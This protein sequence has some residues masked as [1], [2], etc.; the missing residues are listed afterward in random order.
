MTGGTRLPDSL[1]ALPPLRQVIAAHALSA[2]RGLGQNF[3]LDMNLTARIARAAGPLDAGTVIEIGPGPGGLTRALLQA[4]AVRLVAVEKDP[5]CIAAL[6]DLAAAAGGRLT[7]LAADA[8]AVDIAA[9][10]PPPRRI[11]AN[12]PFNIATPL[13]LSWVRRPDLLAHMVLMFQKEVAD[14]IIATAG[15]ADYSRL[16]VICGLLWEARPLLTVPARAFTPQPRVDATVVAVR[17][18]PPPVGTCSQADLETVT[19]AA[20]G[21][22]RKMLRQSLRSLGVE[23][24]EL[25]RLAG[26]DP[27]LRAEMLDVAGFARLAA[28]YRTLHNQTFAA[29]PAT[30]EGAS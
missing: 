11:V 1:L 24:P 3:L 8:L 18:L 19:D 2:R 5:R 27:V 17:P 4:G 6:Q 7:L 15:M 20:F 9:L 13:L 26:I 14:R 22:R 10:G 16:S 30:A 25:L 23:T 12:L 29:L 28:C 21:Q